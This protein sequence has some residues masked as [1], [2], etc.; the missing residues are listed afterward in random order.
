MVDRVGPVLGP[1]DDAGYEVI[2]DDRGIDLDYPGFVPDI[3]A[4]IEAVY[5]RYQTATI[6]F[7]DT[8]TPVTDLVENEATGR[9]LRLAAG[10]AP[11]RRA[12]GHRFWSLVRGP[13]R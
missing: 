2:A 13:G 1:Q 10:H 7:L 5:S 4:A 3:I 11:D 12:A 9:L 8:D 6:R